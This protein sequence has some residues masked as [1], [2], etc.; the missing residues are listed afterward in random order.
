MTR[1]CSTFSDR[2]GL[3][4]LMLW[5]REPARLGRSVYWKIWELIFSFLLH[6]TGHFTCLF[7]FPIRVHVW[8]SI[9]AG[10]QAG[11]AS[12]LSNLHP[13][14]MKAICFQRAPS[15]KQSQP[16]RFQLSIYHLI[17]RPQAKQSGVPTARDGG[18]YSSATWEDSATRQI[19][20]SELS[21]IY[22]AMDKWPCLRRSKQLCALADRLVQ[23]CLLARQTK[24]FLI[25]TR[26]N[27][28]DYR[29]LDL[30]TES[31][32]WYVK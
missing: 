3:I 14:V 19:R 31:R 23:H 20:V 27:T 4:F 6:L 28:V 25:M 21:R 16:K 1:S 12:P 5:S 8:V 24:P 2:K 15:A 7:L 18:C 13:W 30:N 17:H 26:Q 22:H 29:D 32:V 10:E 11:S 9:G